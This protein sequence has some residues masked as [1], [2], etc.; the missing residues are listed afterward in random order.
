MQRKTYFRILPGRAHPALFW[1]LTM[2]LALTLV[3]GQTSSS[4][5]QITQHSEVHGGQAVLQN[6]LNNPVGPTSM[7]AT[8]GQAVVGRSGSSHYETDLGIWSFYLKEPDAP[9]VNA[10]DGASA[11]PAYITISAVQ[12]VL[13]PPSTGEISADSNFPE[14]KWVLTRD[15]VWKANIPVEDPSFNDNQ[16]IYPG[17]L[18]NYGVTTTNKYGISEEGFDAGFT[19]P[20]GKIT[21]RVFT[22]G[23]TPGAPWNPT[24]NPVADVEVSLSPIRGKSVRL[25]GDNDFVS[26]AASYNDQI[27]LSFTTELWFNLDLGPATSTLIDWGSRLQVYHT[28]TEILATASGA[29]VAIPLPSLET[30]HHYACVLDTNRLI[31]YLDGDSVN[32]TAVGPLSPGEELRFGKHRTLGQ[33][34][35]GWLDD[36]RIWKTARTGLAIARNR[37][38]A[39]FGDE[40]DLAG[41]W[42]FDEGVNAISYDASSPRE[43]AQLEGAAWSSEI[44]SI[45][46]SA[47]TNALGNYSIKNIWY[48]ASD[49]NGTTYTVTPF[50]ENHNFFS[51]ADQEASISRNDPDASDVRF[52]DESLFTVSGYLTYDGTNCPVVH[53]EI[54]ADSAST[55]P[56]TFTDAY[57]RFTLDFEP[58]ASAALTVRYGGYFVYDTTH[59]EG[60]DYIEI[61]TS[62]VGAHEFLLDGVEQSFMVNTINTDMAGVDFTDAHTKSVF[63]N[64]GGGACMF[65]IGD[66][67]AE[68]RIP[69]QGSGF[70]YEH[71]IQTIQTGEGYQEISGLPPLSY[72]LI[73]THTNPAISFEP[74]QLNLY[75]SSRHVDFKY[76]SDLQ[77]SLSDFPWGDDC[78]VIYQHE[79]DSL[80]ATVYEEYG[81]YDGVA[82][83][84]CH[85]KSFS[86][87]I[88]DD[89]SGI[90]TDPTAFGSDNGEFWYHFQAGAPNILDGGDHPYQKHLQIVVIDELGRNATDDVWAIIEGRTAT[91]GTDFASMPARTTELPL[92]VLRDPPGDESYSYLAEDQTICRT[93][94]LEVEDE[95]EDDGYAT[96]SLGI[97][98]GL[99]TGISSPFGTLLWSSEVDVTLDLN[100]AWGGTQTDLSLDETEICITTSEI[101]QTDD[102][103]LIVGGE[104]DIFVGATLNLTYSRIL[105]LYVEDCNV[106]VD[107]SHGISDMDGFHS[108][109]VYSDYHIRHTLIPDLV[110]LRAHCPPEDTAR[111][112]QSIQ[113]WTNLLA[114]NDQAKADAIASNAVSNT[115]ERLS[116]ISFDALSNYEFSTTSD[117]AVSNQTAVTI[118]TYD[119]YGIDAGVTWSGVGVV[120]GYNNTDTHSETNDTT[121]AET[122][123]RT[124][125]FFLGD[126]DPGDAFTVDLK[127]DPVWG[128]PV[129]D[130]LGGQ[131]SNPWEANT[132]KRQW[133]SVTVDP[134][135]SVDNEPDAPAIL[136]LSL[137]NLSETGE[138]WAYSLS[139]W[140]ETNPGGAIISVNGSPITGV[141]LSFEIAPGQTAQA[142]MLV[143]RGPEAYIYDGLTLEFAPPGEAEIGDA[144]GRDPQ[145]SSTASFN[146]R[147]IPP[148][149]EVALAGPENDGWIIN[150]ASVDTSGLDSLRIIFTDYD[151]EDPELEDIVLEYSRVNEETW[152]SGVVLEG[153]DSLGQDFW[154]MYWNTTTVP[155][156]D[157]MIRAHAGCR[158]RDSYSELRYGTIDRNSPQILG[159]PEPADQVLNANDQIILKLTEAIDCEQV[160]PNTGELFFAHTGEPIAAVVSC[161]DN[162]LIITPATSVSAREIENKLVRAQVQLLRDL[163]GN[164]LWD[165]TGEVLDTVAWEFTVDRNP[166]HWNVPAVEQISY[167]GE[168]TIIPIALNNNGA[169]PIFFEFGN[170][171][172][173]PDWIIAEPAYGEVN[174]GG[175]MTVYLHLDPYLNLGEYETRIFAE[176]ALGDE[177]LDLDIHSI[178]RPPDWEVHA[179]DYQYSMTVTAAL[180]VQNDVSSDIYD[181]LGAFVGEECRGVAE[182]EHLMSVDSVGVDTLGHTVWET[183]HYYRAFLSAY[184]N[185]PIGE[186]LHFR[187]WD[188]SACDE[189]WEIEQTLAFQANSIHGNLS[190]PTLLNAT[191]AVAQHVDLSQGWTWF[192][193]NLHYAEMNFNQVFDLLN[194]SPGDRILA[195]DTAA[196]AQYSESVGWVGPLTGIPITNV[197]M[198]QADMLVET[199]FPFV[200]FSVDPD[201]TA[202]ELASGWNRIGYTPQV[203]LPLTAAL[204]GLTPSTDDQIKSQIAFAQFDE[205]YGWYGSLDYLEPGLGY[206]LH[207]AQADTLIYP[208]SVERAM[209]EPRQQAVDEL[210]LLAEAPWSVDPY[211]YPANMTICGLLE[212]DT[213]GLND[214]NDAVAAFV[215]EECRGIARP[216]Y[217]PEIEAYRV[218]LVIYGLGS[219]AVNFKIW[220][221]EGDLTYASGSTLAFDTDSRLGTLTDP[222]LILRTPLGIGDKGYIPDVFS[223]SQNYPNPFN[224]RTT[225]GFGIPVDGQVRIRVFNLR[226][227]EVRT[228][229]DAEL[230]AGYRFVVWNSLDD[231]G[232]LLPSGIYLSVMESG[233]FREVKK[234][235]MLK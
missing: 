84:R 123:S 155:D 132:F 227:Q 152:F 122:Y 98:L 30:W 129:F 52:I 1:V 54:L 178:C 222:L 6:T 12:D 220:E 91:E 125:G 27:A 180:S 29:T 100:G 139:A 167:L 107:T 31:V 216:V 233:S 172:P 105:D 186:V 59:F 49:D 81:G 193:F 42:K 92:F 202:I 153:I 232:R 63:L 36:I 211:L 88:L 50:K 118:S 158:L 143:E 57:G 110:E 163:V 14:G 80:K 204:A 56:E 192:S 130:L 148:C 150:Q 69:G 86:V 198:Y 10:S 2:G 151:R 111:F 28:D 187:I 197:D 34:F 73:V 64:I 119:S 9:L 17:Q 8:A 51:P 116:N 95:D 77:L 176:T 134:V 184:A 140:N 26:V 15:G 76:R 40:A 169:A 177:P 235:V 228:L 203:N 71:P 200:G 4:E 160:Y 45:K 94:S 20:N 35:D 67:E 97:D 161:A 133:C 168:E 127:R 44:P 226:G 46:L 108:F 166:L 115:G 194:A 7:T 210:P 60:T 74:L 206:M 181:R 146:V 147:F 68:L 83:N 101:F 121:D 114:T 138:T 231:Q 58:D 21:G 41:Y 224:P 149:S 37:N 159:V 102:A 124:I 162:E 131:T 157:Y 208:S 18:Y 230:T 79:K 62:Y 48:D 89:W 229:V 16:S 156:G 142:T 109:Y 11:H 221:A 106:I 195:A 207:L 165:I 99:E 185:E 47:F 53:A 225:M 32:T 209:D 191:G 170:L 96:I 213:L 66:A 201:N 33:F 179:N 13:S 87:E 43:L 135:A 141:A 72:E 112:T 183:T 218:F 189:L 223:L 38:R 61:D 215:G 234:M 5:F 171:F 90:Y 3:Q 214:P 196:Y 219:E 19:L 55:R 175:S 65:P 164:P 85:I 70:C 212:S 113:Y 120:G 145:N 23:P 39:L 82:V 104:G 154:T 25:D 93:I 22:P 190:T 182:L 117:S 173:L 205:N 188:A 199:S 126:D 24:G 78:A 128:M 136:H 217:V 75:D 174:S 103:G 137:G 144:L